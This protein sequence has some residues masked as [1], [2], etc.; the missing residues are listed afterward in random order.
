MNP[1]SS[2]LLP[3]LVGSCL[4][5]WQCFLAE[6]LRAEEAPAKLAASMAQPV[7]SL[8]I[9]N[10]HNA[11][12]R[13]VIELKDEQ[14]IR[15]KSLSFTLN[16]TDDVGDLD[17]LELFFT[18]DKEEFAAAMAF[19]KPAKP[20]AT[21]L[22]Q[23]EQTLRTGKNVF[24][25]SCRLKDKAGL[26]HR[27]A[28]SCTVI[29]TT[30]GKLTP[31][32]GTPGV[33]HR[34]GIALRKHKDDAV[35]TYRIPALATSPKGTLLCVYDMRRREARDLQEDIDVGL[36]R[37]TDGGQSWEP[38]RVI[39]D[40]GEHGGLPQEQNGCSDPGVIIDQKTGDIF[41]FAVWMNGKP[42]KHQWHGDGSEPG[43]EIGKSAQFLMVRSR[44]DGR[45]WS[46]PENLTRKLKK[47]EWWLLAPSPQQGI[48][49]ADG[50]LVMPV[51]G[52]DD[53]GVR[54]ATVMVSTDHGDNW[55]VGA[56]AVSD[57]NECQAAQLGDSS[58]MLNIRNHRERFRAVYVTRDLGKT[59]KAHETN[60]K[61]LIEPNCNASL[62]RVD[63]TEADAKKHVLLFANPHSQKS[64]THQT[65]QVSFDDGLT[66][67]N[68]YHLLLDEGRGAGYPSLTR[69]DERHVGIV[70]EGSQA[71]LVFE[72]LALEEL[73]QLAPADALT[74][75]T[76]RAAK[77]D[78]VAQYELGQRYASG[79][80]ATKDDAKALA[81]FQKAAAQGHTKAEVSLGSIYAHGF[82]APQ[83]W[84]ES[85][86]WYRLAAAKGDATAQHNLGLDYAHGHG[87]EVDAREASRW[88]RK[89][90]EQGHARAQFNL[91][92]LYEAG[93]GVPQNDLEAYILF[94]LAGEHENQEHIF[95]KD[96]AEEVIAKRVRIEKT[97]SVEQ[98]EDARKQIATA[99]AL[100]VVHPRKFGAPGMI[101]K[102][103]G[104]WVWKK[105]NPDTGEAEVTTDPPGEVLKV[106]VLPWATTYRHLSYGARFDELLPGEKMNMFFD[107][108]ANHRRG[109]VVHFQDEISQ[110]KGHGHAWKILE[111]K[112]EKGF[113]AQV[114]AGDKPLEEK[115]YAFE[116][117]P[118]C[119][120][121][122]GGKLIEKFPM[123]VGDR[124][125]MTWVYRDN[126]RTAMLL[127][128]NASLETLKQLETE[129][130]DKEVAAEGMAGR[131]ETID[132]DRVQFMIYSTW[133]AQAGRLKPGQ[134]VQL[135][136]TGPN[137]RPTEVRV[138][139]KVL[140]HQNR[141]VY[142]SGVNDVMLH[143]LRAD[144]ASRLREREGQVLRL[145]PGK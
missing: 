67:P 111:I 15:V 101:G 139:A 17:A 21:F 100:T 44:D 55:T 70:Y 95:G 87:V 51:Q 81:W 106:H 126:R 116:L 68:K 39:M 141:G 82:G 117:D 72:K 86:R 18:G 33:K 24:W 23:G 121:W 104:W 63:Y 14:D 58:I 35:H 32:D 103:R 114:F 138:E 76:A 93:K 79:Q 36:S 135:A 144:D 4:A 12:L 60:G 128:D 57:A 91:G 28:A 137:Y 130:I 38:V 142:G 54:F 115:S 25:L 145:I 129:R 9:R 75:L 56:P 43:F 89:A 125:Y 99:R 47:A 61:A 124:I 123:Q 41:C 109:Y 46:K 29:E 8:L 119:R 84:A 105:W 16:G 1:R 98:R 122:S 140:S 107:P 66:W 77:G 85:I 127:T 94:S 22:F 10:E 48:N 132:K 136:E 50:S 30:G 52:R 26:S 11:L 62:L 73:L 112:G 13:V 59:W 34:I 96:K 40:M 102:S 108:D 6:D 65:I 133:W 78:A 88:F 74:E 53:K 20:A 120:Q 5:F 3:I 45:T 7:H 110:M 69:I 118:A 27:V 42:G 134:T 83:D 80:G 131:I 143:L 19:G 49:L 71:H 97:L 90:A 31:L 64:R 113:V 37:S 92:E 2:H